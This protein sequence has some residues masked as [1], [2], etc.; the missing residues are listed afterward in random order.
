M[1]STDLLREEHR[2][3]RRALD[4]LLDMAARAEQGQDLN[5]DDIEGVLGFLRGYGDRFHQGKEECVLFPALLRDEDQKYYPRLCGM[6]FE[7][8]RQRF[9]VDGLCECMLAKNANHFIRHARRLNEILISHLHEEEEVL[10]PLV[11]AALSP[12][13][14]DRVLSEMRGFDTAWQKRELSGQ[15]QR[16][17]DLE[18]RYRPQIANR[19]AGFLGP[20]DCGIENPIRRNTSRSFSRSMR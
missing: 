13:E 10:F 17:A 1:K 19:P 14:D 16:L 18:S 12:A 9:L 2:Q 15:L 20:A 8:N 6:V 7:H 5:Q 4:I 3:I 11:G